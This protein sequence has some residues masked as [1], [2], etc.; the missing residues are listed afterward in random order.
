M[1]WLSLSKP[2]Q[3]ILRKNNAQKNSHYYYQCAKKPIGCVLF[4]KEDFSAKNCN[5]AAK[6]LYDCHYGYATPFHSVCNK[7]S[8][9]ANNKH[10]SHRPHPA[11]FNNGSRNFFPLNQHIYRIINNQKKHI[12][13]LQL[14]TVQILHKNFIHKS[15]NCIQNTGNQR[16]G[17]IDYGRVGIFFRN[18][19]TDYSQSKNLP[20]H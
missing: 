7:K 12:P 8:L 4:L 19:Q 17:N 9:V 18:A 5:Y 20:E 16:H 1:W 14:R 10:Y 6:L 13:E 15:R 11:V 2:P 3:F